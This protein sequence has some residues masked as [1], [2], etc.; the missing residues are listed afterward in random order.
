MSI[1][2][3]AI[4]VIPVV[5]A[6]GALALYDVERAP[7][8]TA[9]TASPLQAISAPLET[10]GD[11]LPSD[12]NEGLPPNHPP[13]GTATS[14]LGASAPA[15]SEDPAIAWKMPKGW[16]EAP[17]PNTM[18]LTTYR[19]PGGA[20]VSVSRAG[21]ATQENIERWIA[22]FVHIGREARAEKVVRG[23]HVVTVDVTGTFLGGGMSSGAPAAARSEWAMVGAIVESPGLPY[24]FKMTGPAAA[25]RAARPALDRLVDSIAPL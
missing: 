24:F 8:A 15:M 5:F 25:V 16:Q 23:L 9:A 4:V 20:E 6:A 7:D 14:P 3:G 17:S 10:E 18:R 2:L 22:Q 13:I 19:T 1:R 21:G 12:D 11:E